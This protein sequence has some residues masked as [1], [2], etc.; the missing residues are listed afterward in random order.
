MSLIK[1]IL[2]TGI[3]FKI[4]SNSENNKLKS[5]Q[6]FEVIFY[7]LNSNPIYDDLIEVPNDEDHPRV[8]QLGEECKEYEI[9]SGGNS[10]NINKFRTVTPANTTTY[11]YKNGTISTEFIPDLDISKIE[12]FYTL[13]RTIIQCKFKEN[14]N[15]FNIT[16]SVVDYAKAYSEDTLKKFVDEK[17]NEI[18]SQYDQYK[19]I[20]EYVSNFSYCQDT[21]SY[22]LLTIIKCGDSWATSS[23][24][25]FMAKYA[26]ITAHMRVAENDP[27][28]DPLTV[29]SEI[30]L[31]DGKYFVSKI[32]YNQKENYTIYEIPE[33]YSYRSSE[34]DENK[35]IIYQYDGYD[36][37]ISIPNSINGSIVVGLDKKC[38]INGAQYSD[39][40]I[41][42]ITI[43]ESISFIGDYVFSGLTLESIFIPKSIEYIGNHV[44]EG[45]RYLKEI[46][47]DKENKNFKSNDGILYDKKEEVLLYYPPGKEGEEFRGI[48]DLK[49]IGNFSF[50]KI[51]K[52]RKV[53]LPNSVKLIADKAFGNSSIEE[54]EFEGEPPV[55]GKE[56]FLN[57]FI[58]L[59]YNNSKKWEE[60]RKNGDFGALKIN[61]VKTED[62]ENKEKSYTIVFVLIGIGLVVIIIAILLIIIIQK[63]GNNSTNIESIG[64]EGLISEKKELT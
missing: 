37:D 38:F 46:N 44:F 42:S 8:Y 34:E 25:D 10:I 63:K 35:L 59:K 33:G 52:L 36:N 28:N 24:I 26:N 3:L 45:S 6:N 30:A 51:Q 23:A 61:W 22:I 1:Y 2:L 54:F 62:E 53:Y 31:I 18:E 58:T 43:P 4:I 15:T 21:I 40:Q 41:S 64:E 29:L 7:T 12:I 13:G 39:I 27:N 57:L 14:N 11:Y 50:Y 17:V 19:L 16:F 20:T 49:E 56:P 5:T 32:L 47:V 9:V 60:V 55:F 48:K